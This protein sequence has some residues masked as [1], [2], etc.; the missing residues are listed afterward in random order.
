MREGCEVQFT[1]QTPSRREIIV[2]NI[3]VSCF[4]TAL[5]DPKNV[6]A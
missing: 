3:S 2:Q 5:G 4:P 1:W 6:P